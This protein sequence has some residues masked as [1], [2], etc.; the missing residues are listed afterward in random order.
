MSIIENLGEMS[1]DYLRE[2][3]S[4]PMLSAEETNQLIEQYQLGDTEAGD[5]VVLHNLRLV[6]KAISKLGI[7]PSDDKFMDLVMAGNM[8]LIRSIKTFN[9]ELDYAFSTYASYWVKS[10]ISNDLTS[11]QACT[12]PNFVYQ[13]IQRYKRIVSQCINDLGRNLTQQELLNCAV[14]A[15]VKKLEFQ[16]FILPLYF[17]ETEG[18]SI[19]EYLQAVE[20]VTGDKYTLK[21]YSTLEDVKISILSKYMYLAALNHII[22]SGG[23]F[24]SVSMDS[25][26]P[27]SD[28][29]EEYSYSDKLSTG[30]DVEE[31]A[32]NEVLISAFMQDVQSILDATEFEILSYGFG[33]GVPSLR[34]EDVASIYGISPSEVSRIRNKAIWKL[35]K[36]PVL[37][38]Y[39]ND[40]GY[41]TILVY[42]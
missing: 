19:P 6:P 35:R 25:E 36:S 11:Y 9:P 20:S 32:V 14:L 1:S 17:I 40:F 27:S 2:I 4:Y 15:S 12:L 41:K 38:H 22:N 3:A 26:C 23:G 33:L 28:E 8:G 34:N 42:R 21:R 13:A 7:L 10:Y 31:E 37:R 16:T 39:G 18:M 5:K 29:E 30:E 24:S